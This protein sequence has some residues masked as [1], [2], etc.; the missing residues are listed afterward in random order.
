MLEFKLCLDITLR[1][2]VWIWGGVVWS[3]ELCS[4]ILVDP[5]QLRIFCD[6]MKLKI[7]YSKK[8]EKRL[9]SIY[10]ALNFFTLFLSL[11]NYLSP[12]GT[13]QLNC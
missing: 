1:H 2:R 3:Q 6:S 4:V 5:F 9:Q 7:V 8:Q 10:I 13:V 12:Y 11:N